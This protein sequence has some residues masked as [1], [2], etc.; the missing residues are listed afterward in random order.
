MDYLLRKKRGG[1][2]VGNPHRWGDTFDGLLILVDEIEEK[3]LDRVLEE[4]DKRGSEGYDIRKLFVLLRNK[5]LKGEQ[6]AK[7]AFN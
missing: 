4:A 7:T 6:H 3:G 2:A 1:I 5:L